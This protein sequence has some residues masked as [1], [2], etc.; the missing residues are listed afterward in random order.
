MIINIF[1]TIFCISIIYL[2]Y[3]DSKLVKMESMNYRSSFKKKDK[4]NNDVQHELIFA[5]KQN[6]LDKLD[7][8]LQDISSPNSPNYRKWLTF[9]EV[10]ELTSNP[11]ASNAVIE[12]LQQSSPSIDITWK[13]IRQ[14]YI[15]ATAPISVWENLIQASFYYYHDVTRGTESNPTVFIRSEEYSIPDSMDVHLSTIFNTV[16]SPPVITNAAKRFPFVKNDEMKTVLRAEAKKQDK[17][18]VAEKHEEILNEEKLTASATYVTPTFLNNLYA[19]TTNTGSKL[20]NQSVFE[21]SS[22]YFSPND[23]TTFQKQFSVTVQAAISI[24]GQT[25]TSCSTTSIGNQCD[26]GNLDIQYIMAVAQSTSSIYW[27]VTSSD[28]FVGWIT[29]V[30]NEKYPPQS[31]SISWGSIEQQQSS[32]TMTQWNTEAL[33]LTSMGVTISVSSGDDGVSNSNCAC[34]TNS[35]SSSSKWGGSNSWTGTGYFPSF[36]ATSPYVTAVGATMGPTT[37]GPE[38]VCQSQLGGVITSGGGFS[39]YYAQPSWQTSAV[40]NYVAQLS[41]STTPTSGYNVQ[42][43]GYPDISLIGVQYEVVIAGSTYLLYGTSCSSPVFAAM[44]S[45]VNTQRL[46]MGLSGV[47]FINPTLYSNGLSSS[48]K[49]NDVTSG[50]NKCCAGSNSATVTCC[51]AGFYAAAGW[52]PVSGWGSVNYG[53]L[54]QILGSAITYPTAA[55]TYIRSAYPTP[56]S[57]PSRKPSQVPT[58]AQGQP[59]SAPSESITITLYVHQVIAG[60]SYSSFMSQYSSNIVTLQETISASMNQTSILTISIVTV[61]SSAVSS[62]HTSRM[63]QSANNVAINYTVS[64]AYDSTVSSQTAYNSMSTQLTSNVLIGYFT[65]KMNSYATSNGATSLS[66]ASSSYVDVNNQYSAPTMAPVISP[67]KST[68]PS[69]AVAAI[70]IVILIVVIVSVTAPLY[71]CWWRKRLVSNISSQNSQQQQQRQNP[72]PFKGQPQTPEVMIHG[73]QNN[74]IFKGNSTTFGKQFSPGKPPPPTAPPKPPRVI[75]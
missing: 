10:G 63:L 19:I 7:E 59:T 16:Q 8:I 31:N 71:F 21:T 53:N 23:L 30:A 43:R 5:I 51:S 58:V 46:G 27:Y 12:W 55:P 42:G 75:S 61:T 14:E 25:T 52:D 69:G 64:A 13:S 20:L 29:D 3:G 38:I 56:S 45:L 37:G 66:T 62:V 15:K 70:V 1:T 72:S 28:G 17:D 35:G 39:T 68:L 4:V 44:I 48:N 73:V 9:D 36:P 6:N 54:L 32:S 26:E 47:G 40:S 24:G 50:Y 57:L 65:K 18:L 22:E 60:C 49:F 2:Q 11:I 33:K 34:N 41:S 67:T 74:P